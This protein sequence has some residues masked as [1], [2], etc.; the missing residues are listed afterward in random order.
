MNQFHQVIP[1]HILKAH[2]EQ[3]LKS[4]DSRLR[5]AIESQAIAQLQ[6]RAQVFEE[7]LNLPET[8]TVN[9]EQDEPKNEI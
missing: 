9:A 1:W 7:L 5:H 3:Q 8:L 4:A 6:A 2:F